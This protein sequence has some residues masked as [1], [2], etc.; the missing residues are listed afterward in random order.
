MFSK[1]FQR[2]D[3]GVMQETKLL[4]DIAHVHRREHD[5]ISGRA[6]LDLGQHLFVGAIGVERHLNAGVLR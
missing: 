1:P 3:L 6:R 5:V 2:V 4:H